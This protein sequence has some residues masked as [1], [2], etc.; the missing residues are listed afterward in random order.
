M[1]MTDGYPLVIVDGRFGEQVGEALRGLLSLAGRTAHLARE[2]L[3]DDRDTLLS[4]AALCVRVSWRDVDAEFQEYAAAAESAGCPFLPVAF[5]HPQIRVGPLVV[6]GQPPCHSCFSTRVRQH[7]AAEDPLAEQVAAALRG[8][9][10]LG[11]TGYPPHL[12]TLA[13]ALVLN[14]MG[15]SWGGRGPQRPG[16]VSLINVDSDQVR[17]WAVSTTAFCPACSP[18]TERAA[19]RKVR[20]DRLRALASPTVGPRDGRA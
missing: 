7:S 12:A 1:T 11:V 2:P 13:A 5:S 18:P 17:T 9:P 14:L 10:G 6:P 4:G 16:W 20:Q 8:S 19:L 3:G 15:G